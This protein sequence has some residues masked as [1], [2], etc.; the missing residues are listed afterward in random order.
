[1]IQRLEEEVH[2]CG[3]GDSTHRDLDDAEDQHDNRRRA[4]LVLSEIVLA[5]SGRREREGVTL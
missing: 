3:H 5:L 4:E 1:M 2:E